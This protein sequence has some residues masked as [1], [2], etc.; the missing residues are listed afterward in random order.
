MNEIKVVVS[1]KKKEHILS[2]LVVHHCLTETEMAR[3]GSVVEC[4]LSK[5]S[6]TWS[7]AENILQ[8]SSKLFFSKIFE[9]FRSVIFQNSSRQ[10]LT[11]FLRK[12]WLLVTNISRKVIW[13]SSFSLST[14]ENFQKTDT[15]CRKSTSFPCIMWMLLLYLQKLRIFAVHFLWWEWKYLIVRRRWKPTFSNLSQV[16]WISFSFSFRRIILYLFTFFPSP[17]NG[18]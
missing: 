7:S 10:F 2:E 3:K 1:K 16:N 12:S 4:V 8:D 15:W 11:T 17:S 6:I 18:Q 9:Q 5:L 14:K 13:W